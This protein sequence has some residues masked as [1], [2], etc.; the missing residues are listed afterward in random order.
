MEALLV[1]YVCCAWIYQHAKAHGSEIR[2]PRPDVDS[3]SNQAAV[4]EEAQPHSYKVTTVT[5]HQTR[6]TDSPPIEQSKPTLADPKSHK[7][8]LDILL[9]VGNPGAWMRI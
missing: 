2:L 6:F 5:L 8:G 3:N 4:N 1:R 7:T 9:T